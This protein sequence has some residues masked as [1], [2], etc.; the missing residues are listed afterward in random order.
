[1]EK[2]VAE[3]RQRKLGKVA[4]EITSECWA[5]D[6]WMTAK[7]WQKAN[8]VRKNTHTWRSAEHMWDSGPRVP[9]AQPP[10]KPP[11]PRKADRKGAL[12]W[13]EPLEWGL[14]QALVSA[15]CLPSSRIPGFSL[16]PKN[17]R[18][19]TRLDRQPPPTHGGKVGPFVKPHRPGILND[20]T[21]CKGWGRSVGQNCNSTHRDF[22]L[23]CN[24]D[25][26]SHSPQ[27]R[28]LS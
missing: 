16:L 17:K 5:S 12:S 2:G 18:T 27:Y 24:G 22:P 25:T 21:V 3:K 1:M 19:G 26:D 20:F 23:P 13:P 6:F 14:S 10:W 4:A 9:A 8:E 15:R 11:P 28:G 7:P